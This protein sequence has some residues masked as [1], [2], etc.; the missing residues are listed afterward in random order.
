LRVNDGVGPFAWNVWVSVSRKS[1]LRV[2]DLMDEP[3]REDEPAYFGWLC[4]SIPGY[5]ETLNLKTMV[6]TRVVGLRPLIELEPTEH[7]LAMEQRNGITMD[8]VR[9]IPERMYYH[10]LGGSID[11]SKGP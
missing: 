4:N 1:F 2:C 5:P 3:Q 10:R 11:V 7:P 8:R 9:E 6:H